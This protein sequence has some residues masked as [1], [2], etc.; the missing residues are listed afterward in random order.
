MSVSYDSFPSL[1]F[2]RP[3]PGVLEIVLDAPGLNAV[4]HQA[5]PISSTCGSR[6]TRIP[7]SASR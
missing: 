3:E 4:S 2:E 6:S 7:T 1:T 5:H